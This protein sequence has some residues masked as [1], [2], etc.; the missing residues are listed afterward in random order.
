MS[1]INSFVIIDEVVQKLQRQDRQTDRL[2]GDP[3]NPF[4]SFKQINLGLTSVPQNNMNASHPLPN[5]FAQF[6][7]HHANTVYNNVR[8]ENFIVNIRTTILSGD[9]SRQRC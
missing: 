2:H 6:F 7:T 1:V 4:L 8:F 3:T 5:C 9:H